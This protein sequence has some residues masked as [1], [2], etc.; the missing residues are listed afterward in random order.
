MPS[1]DRCQRRESRAS[2]KVE[3]DPS[4]ALMHHV[5]A[6]P[7]PFFHR[8]PSP[9]ARLAFFGLAV[10]R[11]ACSPTRASA[12][13]KASARSSPSCSIPL[14]RAVQLPGEALAWVGGYFASKRDARPTRTTRCKRDLVAQAQAAQ[15]LRAAARRERAACAR[16]SSMPQRYAGAATAVEVLYTGRDP[17][18]QKVFVNRGSDAGIQAGDAVIDDAG[19]GRPGDARVPVH[20]RSHARHRQGPRGAGARRAQRRAQRVLR[21]GRRAA[22]PSCASWRPP[23][24]SGPATS[25]LTSGI[26]GTYPPGLAVAQVE[27][28]ERETGQMFAQITVRAARRRRPQR[29]PARAR[30]RRAALPPRPEEAERRRRREEGPRQGPQVRACAA[31]ALSDMFSRAAAAHARPPRGDPAAGEPVVHP[32]H[33]LP[34]RCSPTCVAASGHRARCCGPTSSRS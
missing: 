6:D 5:S 2:A 1:T 10:D 16:C 14:Q 13:S 26:D 30:R 34:R 27:A 22:R 4:S 20:G 3:S 18:T 7:P 32:A 9:L 17:F 29:A 25:S 28:V 24:T 8:G 31:G 11:A 33:V 19:R 23:P 12:T 15:E 21:R